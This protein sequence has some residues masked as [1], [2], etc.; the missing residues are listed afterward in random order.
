MRWMSAVLAGVIGPAVAGCHLAYNAGRNA[1]NDPHV[2]MTQVGITHEL[3]RAARAAWEEVRDQYP[4]CTAEFQDGFEDGYVDY[5]DRGGNGSLPAVPPSRYTRH[6]KYFT[7]NG[8]CLLKEYFLGFKHG[9]ETAIATGR[10]QYLTVPVLFPPPKPAPPPFNVISPEPPPTMTPPQPPGP[11]GP[12]GSTPV[13]GQGVREAPR[14]VPMVVVPPAPGPA[15]VLQL[16]PPAKPPG[17]DRPTPEFDPVPKPGP[18]EERVPSPT[19]PIP[20]APEIRPLPPVVPPNHSVPPPLP[21][22]HPQPRN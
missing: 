22:N 15:P 3:R 14:D 11:L 12:T 21:P 9:Q 6:K 16:Q 17:K 8:H 20:V 10:R 5:L 4:H 7:E 19:P 18:D 2:F 13:P 1:I